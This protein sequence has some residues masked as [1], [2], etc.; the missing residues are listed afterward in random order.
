[1]IIPAMAN[2]NAYFRKLI[3]VQPWLLAW[4]SVFNL[5]YELTRS[6]MPFCAL[7]GGISYPVFHFTE[8]DLGYQDW[9]PLRFIAVVLS[10]LIFLWPRTQAWQFSRSL[11]WE[12]AMGFM[13]PVSQSFLFL[14][15][16]NDTYWSSSN[17]FWAFYIGFA[18]KAGW[19]PLQMVLGQL[20]GYYLLNAVNGQVKVDHVQALLSQQ[21]T[22][23]T[24]A[25]SGLGIKIALE[26]FH[27]RGMA[28]A[29]ATA[30]ALEAE[31]REAEMK[32]AY[33][34]LK[35]REEVIKRFVRPSLFEELLAGSDPTQF[36]PVQR[37]LAVMFCDIRDFTQ[38]TERLTS[39]ERQEF[40]NQY[41]SLM[42]E[43]ILKN[44]GEVDKIMGDCV[45]GLFPDGRTAVAA[46]IE[47]RLKLQEFNQ[48]MF[49]L[50]RPKIRNGIGIAKGDVILGNFGSFEKLDRTVI[51]E[52]VNIASRLESKTKMYNLEVIVTQSVI[53]DLALAETHYRWIDLVRVKGSS[54][55]LKLYEIYGHQPKDV[56]DFKD[57]TRGLLEKALTIYFQKGFNDAYRLFQAMLNEVPPHRLIPDEL[58]DNILNYYLAHCE[59]WIH[60][61]T[62]W[63]RIEKWDGVHTFFEK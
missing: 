27:R 15:N 20:G 7:L 24:V 47:M 45:M 63:E 9:I 55:H 10:M 31:I 49:Q 34:E 3:S 60:D 42:T 37:E 8:K 26:I 51:G 40:L 58:M 50:G 23:W 2:F 14:L 19:L 18:T 35:R 6:I 1:M 39:D 28:L 22:I 48:K 41:F 38:L 33:S 11:F 16:V 4:K 32:A 17:T 43:P 54:R 56:R 30:R 13:L 44:G 62:S 59:F 21:L 5:D 12:L 46:A 53:E 61:P 52:S 57:R 36:R 25:L 29:G